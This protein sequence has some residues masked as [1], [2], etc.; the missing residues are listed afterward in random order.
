MGFYRKRN[1]KTV[2]QFS[3]SE[4]NRSTNFSMFRIVQPDSL[5]EITY[6][7]RNKHQQITTITHNIV[8]SVYILYDITNP[9]ISDTSL[10]VKQFCFL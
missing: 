8:N 5:L 10:K 3:T 9:I 4:Y 1:S 7:F 6:T 2:H